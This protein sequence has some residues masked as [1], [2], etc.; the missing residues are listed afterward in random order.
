M[1]NPGMQN[2]M[3]GQQ[4]NNEP[5]IPFM[6]SMQNQSPLSQQQPHPLSGGASVPQGQFWHPQQPTMFHGL[7]KNPMMAGPQQQPNMPINN[8]LGMPINNGLGGMLMGG[9]QF[10]FRA[11]NSQDQLT[12]ANGNIVNNQQQQMNPQ[13]A[14]LLQQLM[15]RVQY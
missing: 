7:I 8:G 5:R 12:D 15:G 14:A 9:S 10:N 3:P 1:G 13:L 2:N 6:Q 4:F 11:P